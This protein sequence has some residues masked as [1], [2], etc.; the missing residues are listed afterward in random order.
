MSVLLNE[1]CLHS[2]MF[3]Y[4][5]GF[6][7]TPKRDYWTERG[8]SSREEWLQSRKREYRH[9]TIKH[10]PLCDEKCWGNRSYCSNKC[11]IL[12]NIKKTDTGC[13]E[14]QKCITP[15][16]YGAVKDLD[17]RTQKT[18]NFVK[19]TPVH[20]LSYKIFK[21]EIPKGK[22]VC[23][24]CDNRCCCNPDH[25]W[26]GS[27]KDNVRDALKKNRLYLKGLTYKLKKG[28]K[29]PASKLEPY[30]SEIRNRISNGERIIEIAES[31]EVTPQAIY[32]IKQGKTW[33]NTP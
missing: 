22:F 2:I 8:F 30:L 18:N 7:R 16:G 31:Y 15:T 26:L 25:L 14:W 3:P 23:H 17:D 33:G 10:C 13:W 4:K 27:P 5:G 1:T 20:R 9:K 32:S 6:M 12:A 21:G 29:S 19:N 24:S 28:G 11:N